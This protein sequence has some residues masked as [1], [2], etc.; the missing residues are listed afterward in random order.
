[1]SSRLK[2]VVLGLLVFVA[3]PPGRCQG[4]PP[5]LRVG[6][7][8][9]RS[10]VAF[11]GPAGVTVQTLI[12]DQVLAWVP[13]GEVWKAQLADGR[14]SAALG[15]AL[16]L[17]PG[18]TL[19]LPKGRLALVS[20]AGSQVEAS[21]GGLRLLPPE[22]G[23][24][25]LHG[26]EGHWD[27]RT[28]R[29]YRGVIE[30]RST[31]GELS[32]V[33]LVDIE[34]YLRGVVPS[35][36]PPAYPLAS[37][38]AQAVAARGQALTKAGRHR[39]EGFDLCSG[40][41][42]QVYGGATSEDP[43][44][45]QAVASTAGEVLIYNGRPSAPLGVSLA[46]G[47]GATPSLS[48]GRIAD[49]LYASVCGGHTANNEDY[50]TDTA[51]VPYLRGQPDFEPEDKVAYQ[52]PLSEQ[53]LRDY[54][55]YAPRVHCNQP[56]YA[57]T[58]KIR[59]WMVV[60]RDD[61]AKT[62]REAVGDFGELLGVRVGERA[63]SGV[64]RRLDVIGTRRLVKVVGGPAVRRALGGLNSASLAIEAYPDDKGVPVAFAIWGAGW[65]HQVGMCQVGA[66]GLADRGWGYERILSKYYPGCALE[67]RY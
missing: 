8:Q 62:L 30:V 58:E 27:Q 46:I 59:W 9:H 3:G 57:A 48:R 7:L 42:C 52:F 21:G 38:Q 45:D 60:R 55:R 28:D 53:Q 65:G 11:S 61:L 37:L 33:N 43:R 64:V 36:M 66:A 34:T 32:A 56:A 26:V 13:P 14:P 10:E 50:W 16:A 4:E 49:T 54:L 25:T 51:P 17:P 18:A 39:G 6:L 41:H 35:E 29:D 19:S 40:Q 67:R 47:A 44:S 31:A 12:G 20:P 5:R 1:M 22:G 2:W 24:V 15:V 23:T 63:P